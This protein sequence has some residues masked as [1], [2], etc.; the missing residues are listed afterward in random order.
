MLVANKEQ[1]L[2]LSCETIRDCIF[3]HNEVKRRITSIV[4]ARSSGRNIV[5]T[6][7]AHRYAP[8]RRKAVMQFIKGLK[9][10]VEVVSTRAA[11]AGE[12]Q[13]PDEHAGLPVAA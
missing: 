1:G 11:A 13:Q 9:P 4:Q 10:F 8:V 12:W 7:A 6:Q 3:R 5:H 2:G